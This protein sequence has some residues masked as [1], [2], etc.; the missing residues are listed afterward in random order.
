MPTAN[1]SKGVERLFPF[2]VRAKKLI[3]GREA[4]ARCKSRLHSILITTDISENSKREILSDFA[5]YPVLQ[6]YSPAELERH[7]GIR[8]ARVIGFEKSSLAKSI[9]AELKEY[10]LNP[11][12]RKPAQSPAVSTSTDAGSP[13]KAEAGGARSD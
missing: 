7:F 2:V 6:K 5:D 9:Y 1:K 4:L 10:R 8:N 12:E 13:A 11:G 3:V